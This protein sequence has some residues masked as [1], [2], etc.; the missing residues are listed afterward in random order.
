MV[1]FIFLDIY[2]F[3]RPE[4]ALILLMQLVFRLCQQLLSTVT[5]FYILSLQS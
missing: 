4:H 1:F 3:G 5:F 2:L